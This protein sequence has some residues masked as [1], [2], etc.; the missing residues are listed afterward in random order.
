[1]TNRVQELSELYNAYTGIYSKKLEEQGNT[2]GLTACKDGIKRANCAAA[3]AIFD[4][5][6]KENNN[7]D[8]SSQGTTTKYENGKP[9]EVN[10]FDSN[11]DQNFKDKFGGF[12]GSK[13]EFNKKYGITNDNED[14][15]KV[16][17][18][19]VDPNKVDPN[20][21]DPNKVDP[22]K[23]DPNKV[24]PNKVDPNKVDPNKVDP[25]K[26]DP[27]KVDPN[28][29]D[30][31][32]VDPNKVDPNK[33]D[34]NVNP[35]KV[36]PNKVDPNKTDT[37]KDQKKDYRSDRQKELDKQPKMSRLERQNRLRFGDKKIDHLK[38]Q[39]ID[40]KTMQAM[41]QMPGA[42]RKAEKLKFI[43]KYPNSITAQRYHGLRDHVEFD[44]FDIVLNHLMETKQVE[45][46]DEALYVMI[47]MDQ[48]TIGGI[49]KDYSDSE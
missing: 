8:S 9:V 23:V 41:S 14:P 25:N 15:N 4:K 1:M 33:V 35:D 47:E 49:V 45:S 28:K 46:I 34:P 39:Q 5:K 16:D 21:V 19:K 24:D 2:S 43:N 26:V 6:Q 12:S 29:V 44:A 30:P 37:K 10:K 36:D 27:N 38:Q 42:D 48:K 3:D 11:D 32:K 20:K 22:N 7:K 18:N 40:F 31:N 13:E 17:P